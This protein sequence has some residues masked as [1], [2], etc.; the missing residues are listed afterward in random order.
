MSIS[1]KD[2]V[3]NEVKAVLGSN[4]N[5]STPAREQLSDDQLKIIK[6]NIV[7]GI[8]SGSI[9]YKKETTDEKEVARYVAGM[10]SNHLRK[11][12]DLNGGSSYAP[13][14]TGRGSRD[15][16][17][18]ELQKLAKTY[19]EGTE[20]FNQIMAAIAS[21]KSEL[22]NERESTAKGRKKAKDL[23][24]INMDVLPEGLKNLASSL[25]SEVNA[26]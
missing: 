21:R 1:Q 2:S 20:E 5:S 22:E 18:S 19:K 26:E 16:Q 17:I 25:V 6:D 23:N 24:S 13:Q 14:S 7:S 10:V 4:F 15:P 12:K 11:A 9:D 8:I 3:V